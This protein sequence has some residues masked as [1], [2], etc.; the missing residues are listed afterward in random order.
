VSVD[1]SQ[2]EDKNLTSLQHRNRYKYALNNPIRYFDPDSKDA[3]VAVEN[4]VVHVKINVA[5][6]GPA[7]SPEVAKKFE[8]Q[9]NATWGGTKT[10]RNT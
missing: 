5:M 6:S 3:K 1:P 2:K 4:K 10:V 9:A 7:A 8:R